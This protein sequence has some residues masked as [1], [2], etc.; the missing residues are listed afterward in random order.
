MSHV[1]FAAD[2]GP[3]GPPGM[4]GPNGATGG[5]SPFDTDTAYLGK[6]L[7]HEPMELSLDDSVAL[8]TIAVL[9][10]RGC[11]VSF[12]V[13]VG[14]EILAGVI[15]AGFGSTA[16]GIVALQGVLAG[17]LAFWLVFLLT[18]V[19]EP[20][21]EWRA[22]LADR[23]QYAPGYYNMIRTVLNHRRLPLQVGA[24]QERQ[25]RLADESGNI[26]FTLVVADREYQTYVTVFGYGTSLYVGWQMWRRRS[27]AQLIRRALVDRLTAVNL[28]TTMLRTDRAR[29]VREAVHL[30]CREALYATPHSPLWAA[31]QQMPLPA[32][33]Y[34]AELLA[35][36]NRPSPILPAP[37]STPTRA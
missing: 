11:L 20:I 2:A 22:L 28:V 36:R 6:T 27:G 16:G 13:F 8:R 10:V 4:S 25:I 1:P 3:S 37:A 17:T 26:K 33:E 18:R 24:V 7:R 29:A 15:A 19:T 35:P 21:S 34:E 12:L 23:A 30:A 32:P 5:P 31:A 14:T 9:F